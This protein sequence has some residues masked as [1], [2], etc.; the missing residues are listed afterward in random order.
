MIGDLPLSLEALPS[1]LRGVVVLE[2]GDVSE[3][4]PVAQPAGDGEQPK[5]VIWVEVRRGEAVIQVVTV[6]A[7][8][9][10]VLEDTHFDAKGQQTLKVTY[11][12]YGGI[13]AKGGWL[14]FPQKIT[15]RAYEPAPAGAT[16]VV[17]RAQVE[18]KLSGIEINP[19]LSEKAFELVF[20]RP[21]QYE[22]L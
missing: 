19:A 4:V 3:V 9:G 12:E 6:D 1:L 13:E 11:A 2:A 15:A 18:V 16:G 21:P 20:D 22:E 17:E 8:G 10:Y 7:E 14:A 5:P